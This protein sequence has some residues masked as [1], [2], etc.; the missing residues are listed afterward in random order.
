MVSLMKRIDFLRMLILS[1]VFLIS[2]ITALLFNV[3]PLK[4]FLLLI[5]LPIVLHSWIFLH[6]RIL[7][8]VSPGPPPDADG[9]APMG[10]RALWMRIIIAWSISGMGMLWAQDDFWHFGVALWCCILIQTNV[11]II[12]DMG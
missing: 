4:A 9:A 12:V 2:I 1:I 5:V 10:I 8:L 7:K 3:I 6:L 11:G